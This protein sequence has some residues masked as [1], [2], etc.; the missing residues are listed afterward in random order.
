MAAI[1][2]LK[3]Y[4]TP[5]KVIQA[6]IEGIMGIWRQTLKKP[7][8][9][10]AEAIVRE[11]EEPVG[12]AGGA[13]AAEASIHH[14]LVQYELLLKQLQEQE[15]LMQ[16][17]LLLV[18]N[19]SKLTA[20]KGIGLLTAA[21]IV[22]EIGDVHRFQ[23]PRQILKMAGLNLREN[24]SGKH[25]GKTTI[26]KRGRR[27]LREGLFNA[28]IPM[29]AN[30]TEFRQMHHRN[31]TREVNPL[32]KMQSIIAL[33]GKLVRVVYTILKKGVEYDADKLTKDMNPSMRV[34]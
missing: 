26:S 8:Q 33:C 18:P 29:L 20:I 17:L 34:A 6:G 10:R 30:N 28:M 31:R 5:A 14:L 3:H 21:V 22:S 24:S 7:S 9:K 16:E 15:L 12:R 23:D 4:P 13:V 2:L 25:K 27:R 19:A 1:S 11:A 32:N